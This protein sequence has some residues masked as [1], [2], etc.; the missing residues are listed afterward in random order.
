[1]QHILDIPFDDAD[2]VGSIEYRIALIDVGF[3]LRAEDMA[4]A[5]DPSD[6]PL[7]V[8]Y[9]TLSGERRVIAGPQSEVLEHLRA[10]GY[11]FVRA[12]AKEMG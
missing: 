9:A 12:E 4:V 3:D 1:M 2:D 10:H 7:R 11:R 8:S 6:D 5:V